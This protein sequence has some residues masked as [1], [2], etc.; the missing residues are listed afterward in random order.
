MSDYP[1]NMVYDEPQT[2]EV[3]ADDT[4]VAARIKAL[5]VSW[6]DPQI[7]LAATSLTFY[8]DYANT[9]KD[10]TIGTAGVITIANDDTFAALQ[11]TINASRYWRMTLVAALPDDKVRDSDTNEIID[12][13]A[14]STDAEACASEVG[15]PLEFDTSVVLHAS[16]C[17]GAESLPSKFP[18]MTRRSDAEN[19]KEIDVTDWEY[20]GGGVRWWR[21]KDYAALIQSIYT[22]NGAITDGTLKVYSVHQDDEDSD[23]YVLV[24]SLTGGTDGSSTTDTTTDLVSV[25]GERLVVRYEGSAITSPTMKVMGALGRLER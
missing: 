1:D 7:T 13:T 24:R 8:S 9:T 23:D 15:S 14:D 25:P 2:V 17:I 3:T 22:A 19:W 12:V 5:P 10:E 16:A 6:D 4:C 20:A 18:F 21:S 11:A